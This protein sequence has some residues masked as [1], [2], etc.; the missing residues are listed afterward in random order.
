MGVDCIDILI[1]NAGVSG[2]TFPD[3]PILK[4]KPEELSE[5]I[6]TNAIGPLLM[7]QAF[8]PLLAKPHNGSKPKVVNISSVMGSITEYSGN[9]WLT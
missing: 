3:E 6:Q 7:T 4:V 9:E 2:Q 1:N 8:F 5:V